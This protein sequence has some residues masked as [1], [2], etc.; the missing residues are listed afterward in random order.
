MTRRQE[1]ILIV[2]VGI[3]MMTTHLLADAHDV[4]REVQVD[5]KGFSST[6]VY[7]QVCLH[8]GRWY[9]QGL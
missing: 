4:C 2:V 5:V 6:P 8:N 9:L 1:F 3:I 7:A